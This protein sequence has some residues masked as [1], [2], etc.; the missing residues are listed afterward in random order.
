MIKRTAGYMSLLLALVL[1]AAV[2]AD[3][4]DHRYENDSDDK[5]HYDKDHYDKDHYGK[6]EKADKKDDDGYDDARHDRGRYDDRYR[7]DSKELRALA[8]ELEGLTKATYKEAREDFRGTRG[9]RNDGGYGR[10]SEA[11][12]DLDRFDD[13]ARVFRREIDRNQ[14]KSDRDDTVAE[15][16]ALDDAFR[17]A[18]SSLAAIRPEDDVSRLWNR[19]DD[20]M[21]ELGDFYG[22]SR[23]RYWRDRD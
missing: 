17:E 15:F 16:R 6:G 23:H 20:T 19:V 14:K 22:G 3:D 10:T 7:Y 21:D 8:K 5:D 18:S 4:R 11:L 2:A 1:T 9:D 12:A 13:R